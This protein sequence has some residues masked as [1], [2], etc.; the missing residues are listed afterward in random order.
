[1]AQASHTLK[2][3]L[4]GYVP[5]KFCSKNFNSNLNLEMGNDIVLE[6]DKGLGFT[7]LPL[8]VVQ[9]ADKKTM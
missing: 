2:Q 9:E 4:H 6:A 3:K 1:M 8:K 5:S 7:I